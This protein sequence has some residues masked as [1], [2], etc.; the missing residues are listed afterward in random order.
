MKNRVWAVVLISILTLLM[1][2]NA[3]AASNDVCGKN[4]MIN[5]NGLNELWIE[6]RDTFEL[7]SSTSDNR[8]FVS[9][10]TLDGI[11]YQIEETINNDYTIV[12]SNFY[13]LGESKKIYLG[14]QH[15]IIEKSNDNV[16]VTIVESGK[17]IDVQTFKTSNE[18]N[19]NIIENHANEISYLNSNSSVEYKWLS[20]GKENGSNNIY[21]YTVGAIVAVLA[22]AAGSAAAAGLAAVASMVIA[23]HWP[24]VYWTKET[25]HYMKRTPDSPFYPSWIS[26]YKYKYYTEY[27]S[28]S[29]RTNL[30]GTSSYIDE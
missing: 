11:T 30:I 25:W 7:I 14:Q 20:Q 12:T 21:R 18:P 24:A 6:G 4:L 3:L 10:F 23:D 1:P 17:T 9:Q 15:T 8:N 29:A 13:R 28:N 19:S 27:Y 22:S 5:E 16:A 26:A 2:I